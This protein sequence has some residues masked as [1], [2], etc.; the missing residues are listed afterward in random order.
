MTTQLTL[1]SEEPASDDAAVLARPFGRVD[2]KSRS[3]ENDAGMT[4]INIWWN[5]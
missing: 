3:S 5:Y 4:I 2:L 1:C